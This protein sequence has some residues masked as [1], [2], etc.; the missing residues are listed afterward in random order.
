MKATVDVKNRAEKDAL[1]RAW[2]DD[3]C[4][5]FVIVMGTLL[6]LPSDRSRARVLSYVADLVAEQQSANGST[7]PVTA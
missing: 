3:T 4:R 2:Q 6:D 5:A 1:E 7:A